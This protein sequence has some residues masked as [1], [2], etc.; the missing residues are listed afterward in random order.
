LKRNRFSRLGEKEMYRFLNLGQMSVNRLGLGK[1]YDSLR[2]GLVHTLWIWTNFDMD[3]N[4]NKRKKINTKK[5]N[6][7]NKKGT[8]YFKV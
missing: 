5:T 6:N 3:K 2:F 4:K 7:N 8:R 1:A